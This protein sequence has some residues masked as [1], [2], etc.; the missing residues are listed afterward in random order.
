MFEHAIRQQQQARGEMLCFISLFEH[1]DCCRFVH[2][3]SAA[4][5][6]LRVQ[7]QTGLSF[8]EQIQKA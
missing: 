4:H 3:F 2:S 7:V 5:K 8:G 6:K 1:S